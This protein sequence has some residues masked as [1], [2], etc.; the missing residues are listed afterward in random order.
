MRR[1]HRDD[2]REH[3]QDETTSETFVL[4]WT[5]IGGGL[6][7]RCGGGGG[8]SGGGGGQS[9]HT[10]ALKNLQ[11]ASSLLLLLLAR[12]SFPVVQ[13]IHSRTVHVE[14][15]SP[16]ERPPLKVSRF[17]RCLHIYYNQR[18]ECTSILTILEYFAHSLLDRYCNIGLTGDKA[19]LCVIQCYCS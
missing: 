16:P 18:E 12:C 8:G 6:N 11:M 10:S 13:Y 9:P 17:L 14:Q 4:D 2:E 15:I 7:G 5:H 19:L 1:D 3:L